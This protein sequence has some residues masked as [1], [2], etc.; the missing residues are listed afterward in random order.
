MN[1]IL[2][3]TKDPEASSGRGDLSL[4]NAVLLLTRA[5]GYPE[6]RTTVQI[7]VYFL[8]DPR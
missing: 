7:I 8:L 2:S 4:M 1:Y 3:T 5:G 6:L